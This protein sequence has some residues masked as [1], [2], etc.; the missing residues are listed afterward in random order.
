M[1]SGQKRRSM[2]GLPA[3]HHRRGSSRWMAVI[4]FGGLLAFAWVIY[5]PAYY[6]WA[7]NSEGDC[8][9]IVHCDTSD[10]FDAPTTV[11]AQYDKAALSP[12]ARALGLYQNRNPL[13]ASVL[14]S[15]K[16]DD[17]RMTKT[18]LTLKKAPRGP[19]ARVTV[20]SEGRSFYAVVR[21][22]T[23]LNGAL[24]VRLQGGL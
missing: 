12:I 23:V 17:V 11:L 4:F 3:P 24:H 1:A 2:L 22:R 15:V 16:I 13:P 9:V 14:Y 8:D 7:L 18:T 21:D 5:R 20:I 6:E 10:F 19:L